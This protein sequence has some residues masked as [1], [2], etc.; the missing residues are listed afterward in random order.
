MCSAA[1]TPCWMAIG[2]TIGSRCPSSFSAAKSPITGGV[3]DSN[4]GGFFAPELRWAGFDHLVISGKAEKPVYLWINDGSI[5][6][7]NA[8]HLWGIDTFET[9]DVI[10]HDHGD[11]EVKS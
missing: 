10:R 7:R 5:E 3:G 2:A 9:Q 6:I 8:S 1:A 4:I 11:E